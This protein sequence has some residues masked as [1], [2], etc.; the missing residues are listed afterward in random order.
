MAGR[1][2][3]LYIAEAD[4]R[5]AILSSGLLA[6]LVEAM[7]AA[8]FTIVGSPK[9]APLFADTPRLGQLIVLEREG[10]LDWLGLW[11]QVRG[12]R[13]GLVVDLRGSALSGKL[14][15]QKRAVAGEREPGLHRVEQ[16]ARVL[17]LDD[18]PAPRLFVSDAT[19]AAVDALIPEGPEP[20]LA[21]GP[22]AEWMGR[23]WPGE[24]FAKLASALLGDAG[25][26]DGG[27]ALVVGTEADRDAA[28]LIR[29]AL[30]RH[31]TVELQGRLTP[32]QAV[33]AIQRAALYVGNDSLWTDLA[34]ASGVPVVAAFG[35]SDDAERGPWGGVAVR[36]PR[37]LDEFRKND[38]KLNQAIQHMNEVPFDRV[39]A[40]A[41][42]MLAK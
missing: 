30:P 19:R 40:A 21:L 35:P 36:G 26:L 31:R 12:V 27:R 38:P 23:I 22:G 25:P 4:A 20:F 42:T 39:L 11:N 29:L 15:R 37:S 5:D 17:Q 34:V 16:A 14:K 8:T 41:K 6:W 10:R 9:S 3:I 18:V 28:H 32:L 24:R 2:P 1:F 33:A 7:P 13:W